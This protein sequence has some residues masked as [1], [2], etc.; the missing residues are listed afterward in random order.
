LCK[1]LVKGFN[2]FIFSFFSY[3]EAASPTSVR[4]KLKLWNS[5]VPGRDLTIIFEIAL[6]SEK[7]KRTTAQPYVR[8]ELLITER[9]LS[10]CIAPL[11]GCVETLPNSL[12]EIA[13]ES[14]VDE[15]IISTVADRPDSR[16]MLDSIH[17][18]MTSSFRSS[19]RRVFGRSGFF[20]TDYFARAV[21]NLLP[22]EATSKKLEEV[23]GL[24]SSVTKELKKGYTIKDAL[25][26][27]LDDFAKKTGLSK[28]KA[29]ITRRTIVE[30]LG[31]TKV[32]KE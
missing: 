11:N 22:V 23:E 28:R 6:R 20:D 14:V 13:D 7:P 12:Y 19:N 27:E 31:K 21:A 4:Y 15:R 5:N 25:N 10:A 8:D 24:P 26:L 9:H 30:I 16:S 3:Y 29:I 32:I 17:R 1:T 18:T 2:R